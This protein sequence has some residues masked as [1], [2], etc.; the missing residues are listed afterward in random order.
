MAAKSPFYVFL[1]ERSTAFMMTL[2]RD[3]ELVLKSKVRVG[4]NGRHGS[5]S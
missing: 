5:A 3:V 4:R 2:A 1:E